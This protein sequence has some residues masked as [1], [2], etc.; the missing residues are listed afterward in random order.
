MAALY[1]LFG[2]AGESGVALFDDSFVGIILDVPRLV[3]A[4]WLLGVVR[5]TVLWFMEWVRW[6]CCCPLRDEWSMGARLGLLRAAEYELDVKSSTKQSVRT[7]IRVARKL[8]H[9]RLFEFQLVSPR[10]VWNGWPFGRVRNTKTNKFF[11]YVAWALYCCPFVLR[12]VLVTSTALVGGPCVC[13]AESSV[14]HQLC[15]LAVATGALV[16]SL[17]VFPAN[18]NRKTYEESW[19]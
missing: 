10:W 6:C 18:V 3:L 17:L 9:D 2:L 7:L 14:P 16:Y 11:L 1:C 19:D 8:E 15:T 4:L 12:I 13:S 5:R